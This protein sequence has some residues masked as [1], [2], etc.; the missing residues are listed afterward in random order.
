ML[1][2]RNIAENRLATPSVAMDS[3]DTTITVNN[4][5]GRTPPRPEFRM[6]QRPIESTHYTPN[7]TYTQRTI[8][9]PGSTTSTTGRQINWGGVIKGVAIVTAVAV[10]AVVAFTVVPAAL[11]SLGLIGEGGLLTGLI[12]TV[13]PAVAWAGNMLV[14]GG[15][16][17]A[18][19]L[20]SAAVAA[21][22]SLGL[23]FGGG[24]A[25][26]TAIST[27]AVSNGVG[28]VAAGGAVAVGV[29]IAAKAV[30]ATPLTDA[31]HTT[32]VTAPAFTGLEDGGAAIHHHNAGAH[33]ASMFHGTHGQHHVSEGHLGEMQDVPDMHHEQLNAVKNASKMAHHA[34]HEVENRSHADS[35]DADVAENRSRSAL[36]EGARGSQAWAERVGHREK[37][38]IAPR[39]SEF[40][41]QLSEDRAQ[42]DSALGSH[43]G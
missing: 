39:H 21:F 17:V 30:M 37:T 1:Q 14:S 28:A 36:R 40:S 26:S 5:G 43:I 29:P 2:P 32:T 24:A 23:S 31:V 4:G 3:A 13:A 35:L 15:L 38:A 22:G 12:N 11:T 42:L 41:T 19:F 6:Q 16:F 10:A 8:T 9:T 34:A 27:A 20:E 25:A 33:G 18:H 7:Q